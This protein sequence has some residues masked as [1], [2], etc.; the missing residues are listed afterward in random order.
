MKWRSR[1]EP[2]VVQW[3]KLPTATASHTSACSRLSS[4]RIQSSFLQKY[5]GN[6]KRQ[7]TNLSYCLSKEDPDGVPGSWFWPCPA[8][9]ITTVSG[10]SSSMEDLFTSLLTP[11]LWNSAFQISKSKLKKE[12]EKKEG[13]NRNEKS[14]GDNTNILKLA[15]GDGSTPQ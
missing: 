4:F 2:I 7:P 11:F 6:S 14:L 10:M 8:L 13:W 15:C 12:R 9:A 1:W 3:T 5:P